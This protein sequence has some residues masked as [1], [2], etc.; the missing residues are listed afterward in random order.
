[1]KTI[2]RIVAILA[3]ALVVVG[4]LIGLRQ[5][6]VLARSLPEPDRAHLEAGIEY[7]RFAPGGFERS[8]RGEFVG[9]GFARG[10]HTA[11]E[12]DARGIIEAVKNLLIIGVIIALVVG[13]SPITRRFLR[14]CS[15][16]RAEA[17]PPA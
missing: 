5:T 2:W 1:M 12:P 9:D 10:H 3:A 8:E 17:R 7:D 16:P 6:E 11:R 4:A 14:R 13:A 15:P